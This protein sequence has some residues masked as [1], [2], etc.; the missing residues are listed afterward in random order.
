MAIYIATKVY[1]ARHFSHANDEL[2]ANDF[3]NIK[4]NEQRAENNQAHSPKIIK[5]FNFHN[6]TPFRENAR[7]GW[8]EPH[9]EHL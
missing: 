9:N 5:S 4:P 7:H 2:G 1:D 3:Q 8:R 6:I